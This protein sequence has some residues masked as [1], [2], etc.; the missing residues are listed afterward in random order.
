MEFLQSAE[1]GLYDL[2]NLVPHGEHHI[3]QEFEIAHRCRGLNLMTRNAQFC[4]T[5]VWRAV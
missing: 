1:A 4:G 2:A 3:E 5:T